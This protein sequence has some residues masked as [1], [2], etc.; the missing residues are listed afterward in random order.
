MGWVMKSEGL[1]RKW[2][3]PDGGPSAFCSGIREAWRILVGLSIILAE[4]A[5]ILKHLSLDCVSLLCQNKVQT[6]IT[7]SVIADKITEHE[8]MAVMPW[9]CT[10]R[11]NRMR[12]REEARGQ[13]SSVWRICV[14]SCFRNKFFINIR[15]IWPVQTSYLNATPCCNSWHY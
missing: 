9:R 11:A 4:S 1:G 15:N 12:L 6:N 2:F 5:Q 10:C 7:N 13:N 3:W 8:W 14:L